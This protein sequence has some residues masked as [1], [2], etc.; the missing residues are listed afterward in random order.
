MISDAHLCALLSPATDGREEAEETVIENLRSRHQGEAHA[1]PQQT[2]GV[3]DVGR[4]GDLFILHE[5]LSIGILKHKGE[6]N[7]HT[8]DLKT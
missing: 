7:K 2:P 5:P 3:G 6:L 8:F 1:E 4:L